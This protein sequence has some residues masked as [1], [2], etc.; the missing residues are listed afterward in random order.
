MLVYPV[1]HMES[2]HQQQQEPTHPKEKSGA[3]LNIIFLIGNRT[4]LQKQEL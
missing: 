2:N 4:T 3:S 1:I